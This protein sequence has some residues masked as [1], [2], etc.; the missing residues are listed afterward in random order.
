MP[1]SGFVEAIERFQIRGWA[2]E[3]TAPNHHIKIEIFL[4]EELIASETAS[5]FRDDLQQAGVG[6]GDHA[7]I[8]NLNRP[9][10]SSDEAGITV[11]AVGIDNSRHL[12]SPLSKPAIKIIGT[13]EFLCLAK[14]TYLI[15]IL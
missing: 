8:V 9:L 5:L 14:V 1:L 4:R 3:P 2:F 13:T 10:S 12:L 6:S 11:F 7:F 15:E